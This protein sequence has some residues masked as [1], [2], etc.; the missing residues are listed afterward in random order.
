MSDRHDPAA[1]EHRAISG[2]VVPAALFL[3]ALLLRIYRLGEESLWQD[4]LVSVRFLDVHGL[5]RFLQR[6]REYDPP[7]TPIYF[8]IEYFWARLTGG[9]IYALRL[10]SVLFAMLSFP[11]FHGIARRMFDRRAAAW[12]T[13]A[14]AVSETHIYYS[15][16]IRVYA[17]VGLLALLAVYA[18]LRAL[19]SPRPARWWAL[20]IAANSILIWTH[21]YAPLLLVVQGV[22]LLV[23]WRR[24]PLRT[25]AW[26]AAHAP[27]VAAL[28]WWISTINFETLGQAAAWIKPP[29]LHDVTHALFVEYLG[30]RKQSPFPM[31]PSV[32]E[33]AGIAILAVVVWYGV[34]LARNRRRDEPAADRF[35]SFLFLL[36]WLLLPPLTLLALSYGHRPC[37]VPRYTLYSIPPLMI[38]LGGALAALPRSPRG[39]GIVAAV[40]AIFLWHGAQ[41]QRPQRANYQAVCRIL[42][43]ERARSEPLIVF[44]YSHTPMLEFYARIP[45]SAM[46]V[47]D[48]WTFK[49]TTI[50]TVRAGTPAWVL[51]LATWRELP[52]D[53]EDYLEQEGLSFR[54]WAFGGT[55]PLHLY[56]VTPR[57]PRAP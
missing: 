14:L 50:D 24:S 55:F 28:A 32:A 12:A 16:E 45:E 6:Y 43:D 3:L 46:T 41:M 21:L 8:V 22:H 35:R 9:S 17:L 11:L 42:A 19:E 2:A 40:S 5:L 57:D 1:R 20:N 37:F 18:M 39:W 38:M 26:T 49:P 25:A 51:L 56:H 33:L 54:K 47:T 30:L 53:Y 4:E 27:A 48:F 36:L 10:L 29:G 52:P 23:L 34:W 31:G 7:M 15:Q 44:P 13:L